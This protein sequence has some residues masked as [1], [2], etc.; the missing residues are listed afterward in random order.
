MRLFNKSIMTI[1]L[2]DNKTSDN[3]ARAIFYK[4]IQI[5]I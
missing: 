5:F 4:A 1:I 2:E 3:S